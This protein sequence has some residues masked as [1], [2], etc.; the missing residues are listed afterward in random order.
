MS[1]KFLFLAI[2]FL[3]L[4]F[5]VGATSN[6][7]LDL[8]KK[9]F[10]FSNATKLEIASVINV[11]IY[12]TSGEEKIV[13]E[14]QKENISLFQI[15]NK[16]ESLSI[17]SKNHKKN[18]AIKGQLSIYI[19]NITALTNASVGNIIVHDKITTQGLYISNAGVGNLK[20]D[21]A[22]NRLTLINKAVGNVN[23]TG[24]VET[25]TVKNKGVGDISAEDCISDH[26][27]LENSAVGNSSFFA[28]LTFEVNNTA[29]G[30]L[31]LYG[32]GEKKKFQNNGLGNVK[33]NS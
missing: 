21:V 10:P 19:K 24:K 22:C 29:V 6:K 4:S 31:T 27:I 2:L 16:K 20:L 18:N 30:N 28:N 33:F 23:L 26:L 13:L 15:E 9:T 12:I 8:E 25:I 3:G 17:K 11:H 14:T 7:K 5:T 32:K 1:S